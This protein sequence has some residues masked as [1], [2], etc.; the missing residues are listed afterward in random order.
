[1][2]HLHDYAACGVAGSQT[3]FGVDVCVN[4]HL[5]AVCACGYGC[6]FEVTVAA[7]VPTE[8]EVEKTVHVETVAYVC[9]AVVLVGLVTTLAEHGTALAELVGKHCAECGRIAEVVLAGD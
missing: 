8:V 9:V 5:V 1:M 6:Y 2:A 4:S 3:A 7:T